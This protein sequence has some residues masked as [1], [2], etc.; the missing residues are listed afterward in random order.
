MSSIDE[1]A[2]NIDQ[3]ASSYSVLLNTCR[4]LGLYLDSS[5]LYNFRDAL[6]HYRVLYDSK[7]PNVKLAQE[8]SLIEHLN[9]GLRDGYYFILLHLKLGIRHE[10][11]DMQRSSPERTAV[12]RKQLHRYKEL[13][14]ELR[15][16]PIV[17][18]LQIII[19][20]IDN[21][22]PLLQETR[23]LFKKCGLKWNFRS[24]TKIHII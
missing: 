16:P 21:L 24:Y 5:P 6:A 13:E 3:Y 19:S 20:Y 1:I 2:E 15:G 23:E 4:S 12:F 22:P 10:I 17:S 8:T 11:K 7:D 18:D 14:L 9:R